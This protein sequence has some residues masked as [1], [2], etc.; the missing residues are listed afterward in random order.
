MAVSSSAEFS[1]CI[2][3]IASPLLSWSLGA[4]GLKIDGLRSSDT[5]RYL[6]SQ[7]FFHGHI[8]PENQ[9]IMFKRQIL[10]DGKTLSDYNLKAECADDW[11]DGRPRLGYKL[12]LILFHTYA[13]CLSFIAV[14][15]LFDDEDDDLEIPSPLHD[16][17]DDDDDDVE[18]SYDDDDDD[19]DDNVQPES[20]LLLKNC[21]EEVA[22]PSADYDDDD[23]DVKCSPPLKKRKHDDDDDEGDEDDAGDAHSD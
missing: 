15:P 11:T 3:I 14:C 9:T 21:F 10:E 16:D 7:I 1:V 18:I 22:P 23:D 5:V 17:E 19:D 20:L 4:E 6:K 13:E 8:L 2:D 12:N